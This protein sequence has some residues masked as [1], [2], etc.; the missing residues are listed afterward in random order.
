MQAKSAFLTALYFSPRQVTNLAEP[1][2]QQFQHHRVHRTHVAHIEPF[3]PIRQDTFMIRSTEKGQGKTPFISSQPKDWWC[4]ELSK[5]NDL[6]G[7]Q[8][9]RLWAH[10]HYLLL[11]LLLLPLESWRKRLLVFVEFLRWRGSFSELLLTAALGCCCWSRSLLFQ[12]ANRGILR[13][14]LRGCCREENKPSRACSW[15]SWESPTTTKH[16]QMWACPDCNT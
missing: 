3:Y 1:Y 5:H 10:S 7:V 6:V 13:V 12:I 2:P 14:K 15:Q 9:R 16:T 4:R 8:K 11:L